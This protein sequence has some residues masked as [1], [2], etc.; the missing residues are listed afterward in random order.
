MDNP[1]TVIGLS[2]Y[3][4]GAI[5]IFH[6]SPLFYAEMHPGAL[7]T[8]GQDVLPPNLVKSR[9]REIGCNNDRI[10][11]KFDRD[12]GSVAAMVLVKVQSDWKSLNPNLA[13]SRL[14]EIFGL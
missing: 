9:S 7:F 14:H 12:L 4:S 2:V 8:M 13:G 11:L 1:V 6:N 10:V 5:L 3:I